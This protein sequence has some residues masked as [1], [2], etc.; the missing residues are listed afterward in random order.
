MFSCSFPGPVPDNSLHTCVV[1][2]CE[3][4]QRHPWL[5][6]LSVQPF[7][8]L[9]WVQKSL[10]RKCLTPPPPPRSVGGMG[11]HLPQ[12]MCLGTLEG[13]NLALL[14]PLV[15][16]LADI[17]KKNTTVLKT[18]HFCCY[19]QASKFWFVQNIIV[20]QTRISKP[21]SVYE[22]PQLQMSFNPFV[23]TDVCWFPTNQRLLVQMQR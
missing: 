17:F 22:F 13:L 18:N 5:D 14:F 1:C 16:I 4:A 11:A 10:F 3:R 2:V 23:W 20:P 21:A 9:R 8:T 7:S 12:C 19:L 15:F 6:S